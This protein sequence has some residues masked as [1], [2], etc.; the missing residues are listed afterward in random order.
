M[1]ARTPR[2]PLPVWKREQI[3]RDLAERKQNAPL[4]SSQ[5][6]RRALRDL[7]RQAAELRARATHPQEEIPF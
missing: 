5:L 6:D 4:A 2:R 7:R 3:E 1:N